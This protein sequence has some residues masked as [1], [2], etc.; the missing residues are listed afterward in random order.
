LVLSQTGFATLKKKLSFTLSKKLFL[1]KS[2]FKKVNE[3]NNHSTSSEL[4]ESDP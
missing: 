3:V 4:F 2:L 1:K